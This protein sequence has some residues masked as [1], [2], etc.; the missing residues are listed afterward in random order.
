MNQGQKA[1]GFL[2]NVNPLDLQ[3]SS[4]IKTTPP[5]GDTNPLGFYFNKQDVS[6]AVGKTGGGQGLSLEKPVGQNKAALGYYFNK[7]KPQSVNLQQASK[8]SIKQSPEH[9][10]TVEE[11]PA[12]HGKGLSSITQ[13]SVYLHQK[14][15]SASHKG[16]AVVA[17]VH[18]IQERGAA[19]SASTDLLAGN[20]TKV[21]FK[22][23]TISL[24][25]DDV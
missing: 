7:E 4:V 14:D 9:E 5:A 17:T 18:S 16:K 11:R 21:D 8:G 3:A 12:R 15:H 23:L 2:A 6:A 19:G 13:T 25:T 22:P 20:L 1:Q 10:A 24:N